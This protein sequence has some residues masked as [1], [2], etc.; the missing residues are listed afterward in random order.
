MAMIRVQNLGPETYQSAIV[1]VSDSADNEL[2][3]SDGNNEFLPNANTCP[4]GQ[5]TL[6]PG[7]EKFVAI[8]VQS[9]PSGDTL[10]A[11]V[12]VCTEKGYGGNCWGNTVRFIP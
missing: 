10:T 9:A 3:R 11:R 1:R 2:H 5:P 6:G 7:E 12:T 8:S 4:G